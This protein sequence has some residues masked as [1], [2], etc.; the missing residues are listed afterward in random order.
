MKND[1][2]AE[3]TGREVTCTFKTKP[4][5]QIDVD[6]DP[7]ELYFILYNRAAAE[8]FAKAN[9]LEIVELRESSTYEENLQN[10]YDHIKKKMLSEKDETRKKDY[11]RILKNWGNTPK[12]G[13]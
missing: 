11:E 7:E 13:Q 5:Y 1:K 8:H 4:A 12:E 3:A 10:L 9:F 2:E 6:A